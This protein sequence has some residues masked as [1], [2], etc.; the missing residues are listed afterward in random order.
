MKQFRNVDDILEF[1]ITEEQKAVDFYEN[2]AKDARSEQM[3][4]VFIEFAG[5]EIKHKNRLNTIREEGVFSMP[6]QHV[7]DLK[8]SDYLV[9]IKPGPRMTYEEVLIL[10]MNK[11]KASFRLYS[12]L[13]EKAPSDQLKQVFLSLAMEE[14]RHKLRFELEY[15][16]HV[17]RDM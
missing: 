13:S 16:E 8:I 1:A 6:K 3:R 9:N 14:S 7:A 5:E 11:E 12:D 4:Q 17:L 15:D 2:L 10:A